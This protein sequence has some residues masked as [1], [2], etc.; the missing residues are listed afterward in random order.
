MG[1]IPIATIDKTL[2][3]EFS[4]T[5]WLQLG[6]VVLNGYEVGQNSTIQ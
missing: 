3:N 2:F 6:D 4:S 5:D 1:Y